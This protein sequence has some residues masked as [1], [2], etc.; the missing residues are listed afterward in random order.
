MHL[1]IKIFAKSQPQCSQAYRI[2]GKAGKARGSLILFV[3]VQPQSFF[4]GGREGALSFG[5]ALND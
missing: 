2:Y 3:T 1:A 5:L 4:P